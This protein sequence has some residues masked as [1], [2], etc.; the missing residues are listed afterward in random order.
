MNGFSRDL[1]KNFFI[2]C[3]NGWEY[4]HANRTRTGGCFIERFIVLTLVSDT[5]AKYL[6]SYHRIISGDVSMWLY[7]DG[8]IYPTSSH[9]TNSDW[10]YP[11]TDYPKGHVIGNYRSSRGHPIVNY[12]AGVVFNQ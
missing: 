8:S 9:I 7:F 1:L 2:V 3:D 5:Y 10:N 11:G 6:D 4:Y 12:H